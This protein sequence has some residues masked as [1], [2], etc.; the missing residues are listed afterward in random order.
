MLPAIGSS[1]GHLVATALASLPPPAAS[2]GYHGVWLNPAVTAIGR[3]PL[4]LRPLPDPRLQDRLAALAAGDRSSIRLVLAGINAGPGARW[5]IR[6]SVQAAGD[7]RKAATEFVGTIGPFAQT[8]KADYV[9][10]LAPTLRRL[11]EKK[12][13]RPGEPFSIRLSIDPRRS[14]VRVERALIEIPK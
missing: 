2:P 8:G 10:D 12:A 13:W 14:G 9:L 3:E 11:A 4:V 6:V 7:D 1:L 5:G